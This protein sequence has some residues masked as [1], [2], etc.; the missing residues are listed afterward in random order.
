M[1]GRDPATFFNH[2]GCRDQDRANRLRGPDQPHPGG[3][4]QEPHALPVRPGQ[5]D[6]RAHRRLNLHATA[7]TAATAPS[8]RQHAYR[9]SE[10]LSRMPWVTRTSA[11]LTCS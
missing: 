4:P 1:F 2:G 10:A 3:A 5:Q 11:S 6:G 8:G 9:L 7:A